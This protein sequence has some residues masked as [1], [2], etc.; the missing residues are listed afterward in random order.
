MANCGWSGV[1]LRRGRASLLCALLVL[2]GAVLFRQ[3]AFHAR[4]THP[5]TSAITSNSL[6][7]RLPLGFEPN[8]GQAAEPVKFVARGHG[9]GLYLT[10]AE[11]VL[12]LA[13]N[14]SPK[15]AMQ[16]VGA[17]AAN[18]T[19]LESLPGHTNYFLGNDPSRWLRNVPQ[20]E[21]VR[22]NEL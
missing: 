2:G 9:Y 4:P 22:Y 3:D 18:L 1:V 10:P 14:D 16:F 11:A 19:A 5:Q 15:I 21:R 8:L 12:T 6:L 7:A 20:F 17:K 13:R